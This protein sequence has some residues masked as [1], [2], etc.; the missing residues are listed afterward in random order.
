MKDALGALPP[1]FTKGLPGPG[2]GPGGNLP[3]LG[4]GAPFNLPK[5]FK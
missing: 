2:M 1:D 5:K 4:G 3:G